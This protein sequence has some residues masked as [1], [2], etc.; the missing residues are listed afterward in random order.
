MKNPVIE[1][2]RLILRPLTVEDAQTA[3]DSWTSDPEV[4]KYMRYYAHK[5]VDTTKEWLKSVVANENSDTSFDW[6]FVLCESGE[7]VGSGGLYYDDEDG[8]F[9]IG[10]N[11]AKKVWGRGLATEAA[12]AMIDFAFTTLHQTQLRGRHNIENKASGNVMK[13][14][15]FVYERDCLDY[16]LEDHAERTVS[17]YRLS[18]PGTP[19]NFILNNGIEI[20][21]IGFGSY[22]STLNDGIAP[23]LQALELGYRYIDTASFYKNEEDIGAALEQSGIQRSEIFLAT[24]MWP[25]EMGY[26]ETMEAFAGS[27]RKLRTD[28]ID[29]YLI[30]WPKLN[31]SDL[32]WRQKIR[33]TWRAM[34]EL[35]EAGKCRAIGVCNFQP[36]H[37]QVILDDCKVVPMVDQLELHAGYIQQYTLDFCRAHGI[38]PQA[39]SP[40]G[41]MYFSEEPYLQKMAAQYGRPVSQLLLRFLNQSGIQII[42]KSSHVDRMKENLDIFGFTINDE[43]MSFLS[44]LPQV[45]FSK[46]FPDW[47]TRG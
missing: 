18:K 4:A 46:E 42:P 23:I 14:C 15:G 32:Q 9:E 6:G 35:Y 11:F 26:E 22:R 17:M 7:L 36:H 24:K 33:D 41:R 34:E 38:V 5:S 44:C 39:W 20:P 45:G 30:H 1:T 16:M 21:P 43:D 3:F 31:P 10:Y 47:A 37:L 29:L 19:S 40:L 13:K 25:T 28:Y 12:R 2:E 27:C 8:M